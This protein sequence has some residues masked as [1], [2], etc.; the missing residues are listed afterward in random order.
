MNE[1]GTA[2]EKPSAV[3]RFRSQSPTHFPCVVNAGLSMSRKPRPTRARR[4]RQMCNRLRDAMRQI[5][6]R[7]TVN[8]PRCVHRPENENTNFDQSGFPR[9][10]L[11]SRIAWRLAEL[12]VAI[13]SGW[14]LSKGIAAPTSIASNATSRFPGSPSCRTTTTAQ[15][16][17]EHSIAMAGSP[18]RVFDH[19]LLRCCAYNFR[20]V[21]TIHL[22]MR[23][24]IRD[25]TKPNALM[26]NSDD[27]LE[28]RVYS[29][30]S[31]IS[32]SAESLF[33]ELAI[34]S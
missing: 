5:A 21:D 25:V 33:P 17:F 24:V 16:G 10:H 31:S 19:D 11:P 18:E 3:A 15:R 1:I 12:G 8:S 6:G 2:Y 22:R 32:S 4:T 30:V 26:H 28:V 13:T 7:T 14:R 23:H 29:S 27:Q 9:T 34:C 20:S